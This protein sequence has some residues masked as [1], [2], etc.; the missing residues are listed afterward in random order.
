MPSGT[1]NTPTSESFDQTFRDWHPRKFADRDPARLGRVVAGA[2]RSAG[3][4]GRVIPDVEDDVVL[5]ACGGGAVLAWSPHPAEQRSRLHRQ[6]GFLPHFPHQRLGVRLA[7]LDPPAGHRPQPGA[8]LMPALDE[9]QPPLIIF[10]YSTHTR[11]HR[12]RHALKYRRSVSSRQE[13]YRSARHIRIT[14][15]RVPVRRKSCDLITSVNYRYTCRR[16]ARIRRH[17]MG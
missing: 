8:R 7:G 15:G 10:D 6:A 14:A 5:A 2:E 17:G 9:Q 13:W 4:R 11:D 12:I 3:D 16:F 1:Q